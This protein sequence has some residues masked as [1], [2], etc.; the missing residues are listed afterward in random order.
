MPVRS[1]LQRLRS[2]GRFSLLLI[3]A[4]SVS[5]CGT[6]PPHASHLKIIGGRPTTEYEY[7]QVV[8]ILRNGAPICSGTVIAE[9][10][11]I[12]AAHCFDSMLRQ[13][14]FDV[15]SLELFFGQDATRPELGVV[16]P[17]AR[18]ATHPEFWRG[19]L[20]ALDLAI[21]QSE[22]S[23]PVS[24]PTELVLDRSN[25]DLYRSSSLPT[26]IVGFGV[27]RN[28]QQPGSQQSSYGIKHVATAWSYGLYGGDI[29]IGDSRA[30]TCTGDS[31]G[32]AFL[33]V[34]GRAPQ[35]IGITSRGPSPCA[36]DFDPGI[37]TIPRSGICWIQDVTGLTT[38]PDWTLACAEESGAATYPDPSQEI[39]SQPLI[40]LSHRNL[41]DI[42]WIDRARSVESLNLAW[43]R[44]ENITALLALPKLKLLDIRNNLVQ[45]TA[46]LETLK[47]RGV[48]ILGER[49]QAHNLESTE[50]DRLSDMGAAAGNENRAT[51]LALR[52]ILTATGDNNRKS[53]DLAMRKYLG[54][55]QRGVRGLTPLAHLENL[56]F[57]HLD[58]NPTIKD[59]TPLLTL[60]RLRY[61]DLNGSL[62]S[63][64]ANAEN[65]LDQLRARGVRVKLAGDE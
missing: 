65:V 64:N 54:L 40:D 61:L 55:S 8:S 63:L 30:D 4:L 18:A 29:F 6:N 27:T 13:G 7:L 25:I 1:P 57:L 2:P 50:F 33:S 48:T 15:S 28:T 22:V 3:A 14:S 39:L 38:R 34:A 17:V 62:E 23:L 56:E 45:D 53:R 16:I 49:T 42:S 32:P 5:R 11:V 37:M 26:T 10:T 59:L 9:R 36:R 41:R 46:T 58:H 19:H 21:L 47:Q 35:L 51:V 20:S 12:S 44:I 60:P 52:A 24:T 31:G 43:N